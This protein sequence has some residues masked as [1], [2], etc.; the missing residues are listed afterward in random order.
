M[1][2][3]YK[4]RMSGRDTVEERDRER[5]GERDHEQYRVACQMAGGL[6]EDLR[7]AHLLLVNTDRGFH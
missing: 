4:N 3:Y 1:E 6:T 2:A 5:A 7:A